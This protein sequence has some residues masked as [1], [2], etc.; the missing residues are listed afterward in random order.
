LDPVASDIL[1]EKILQEKASGKTIIITSHLINE[2]EDLSERII[3]LL[4]GK[5]C[6]H[7][8]IKDLLTQYQETR[9]EKAIVHLMNGEIP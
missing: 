3:F 5:L 7:G 2:L 8:W 6:Y 4:E 9:L 1:K